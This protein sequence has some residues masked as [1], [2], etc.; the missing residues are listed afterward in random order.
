VLLCGQRNVAINLFVKPELV[1]SKVLSL[2]TLTY[3]ALLLV[4]IAWGL[5]P[6][7][8]APLIAAIPTLGLNILS[9][10]PAQRNLVHQYSLPIL[11]FLMVAVISS[12][13]AGRWQL[14]KRR[15]IISWSLVCFLLLAKYGYFGSIYL[16]SLGSLA[17]MHEAVGR[18]NAEGSVFTT[19][20]IVP[21]L[22]HRPQI[23]FTRMEVPLPDWREYRYVL[24]NT[25]YPGWRSSPE[26]ARGIVEELQRLEDFVLDYQ[27][28][29][30][31]LFVREMER[32][33]F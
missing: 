9:D 19:N 23:D 30:V 27:R 25:D 16:D 24:L 10:S 4:P 14:L 22:T 8:L 31:Y 21:H 26:Y 2:D 12:L 6:K 29:G 32:G 13:A 15:W 33:V 7:H 17:A 18:V 20:E 5:A 28:D 1:F 3:L 11:P